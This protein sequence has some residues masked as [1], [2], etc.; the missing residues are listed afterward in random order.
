MDPVIPGMDFEAFQKAFHEHELPPC[1]RF[2]K[3]VPPYSTKQSPTEDAADNKSVN[4]GD[5][6]A[7]G[8]AAAAAAE[9]SSKDG[10]GKAQ[11]TRSRL[12]FVEKKYCDNTDC[13]SRTGY[14]G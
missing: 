12:S 9:I 3:N 6:S 1:E 4:S 10:N 14:A 13:D 8:M 2:P 11:G 7:A 5:S